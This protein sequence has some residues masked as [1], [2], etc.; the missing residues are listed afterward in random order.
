MERRVVITAEASITPIGNTEKQIVG[1]LVNGR[2]GVKKLRPPDDFPE[3]LKSKV[4]GT[5]DYEIEH[6]FSRKERKTLSPVGIYAC[7]TAKEV[8][9]KSGLDNDFIRSGRLGVAF[10]SLQGSPNVQRGMFNALF[11]EEFSKVSGAA[12]IQQ[13]NHTTAANI[14]KMFNITGRIISSTTACTTSSQSIG[15]GYEAI[16]H[17]KQD[18]MLCGGSDEYDYFTIAIFDKLLASSIKYNDNPELTPR[19]FDK[20][21]DGL[22]VGEGAGAVLLEEY[23]HAKKRNANILAEVI[24][25]STLSNGG[26][27]VHP[28]VEGVTKTLYDG[29]SDAQINSDDVDF[30]SSHATAT[31][32]GDIVEA[33]SI[34][35]V[36]RDNPFVTSFKGYTGHTMGA[37][38][39]METIFTLYMMKN[40]IIVPTLNL[41][42]P[43]DECGMINHPNKVIDKTVNIASV[44]NFAFGGVNTVL[45]LRRI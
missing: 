23:E 17:G 28:N 38:G 11:R 41:N 21:R 44:Q 25:F 9:Q 4:F 19:P 10:G 29:L 33:K 27:L 22:V 2:S 12:Y 6:N 32:V 45:Y 40:G 15:F 36:Y 18:A 24:G 1:N 43:D 8:L 39:V 13:M 31:I 14:S 20:G 3:E 37:C 42:E 5:V 30:V 34:Y 7:Q 35:N 16:R 26:D